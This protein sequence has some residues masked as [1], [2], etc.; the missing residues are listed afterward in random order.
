MISYVV[1]YLANFLV[2]VKLGKM[3]SSAQL[4]QSSH[5]DWGGGTHN[6]ISYI[7]AFQT[8]SSEPYF[9]VLLNKLP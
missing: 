3:K 4:W 9:N 1:G 8:L 6:F 2:K 5:S 7:T